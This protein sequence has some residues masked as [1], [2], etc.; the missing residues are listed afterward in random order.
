MTHYDPKAATVDH[1]KNPV[2]ESDEELLLLVGLPGSESDDFDSDALIIK[3][4]NRGL[5]FTWD[6]H[7]KVRDI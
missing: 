6:A 1:A 3:S 4:I 5:E 2:A 7:P